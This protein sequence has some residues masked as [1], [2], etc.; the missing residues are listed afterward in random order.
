MAVRAECRV[1]SRQ[2]WLLGLSV[3]VGAVSAVMFMQLAQSCSCWAHTNTNTNT[4]TNTTTTTTT[5][6][7]NNNNNEIV[8][9]HN[10]LGNS[11]AC[12]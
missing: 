11:C 8:W 4:N 6:N 1:D 3:V 12:M 10:T 5:N 9:A 7:N 2:K